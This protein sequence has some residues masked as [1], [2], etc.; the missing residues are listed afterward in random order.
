MVAELFALIGPTG[1]VIDAQEGKS[2]GFSRY[3]VAKDQGFAKA[4]ELAVKIASNTPLSNFAVLQALPRIADMSPPDGLFV[5]ALMIGIVQGDVAAKQRVRDFLEHLL[6]PGFASNDEIA[7]LMDVS[8]SAVDGYMRYF[9]HHFD[10][11]SREELVRRALLPPPALN[12]SKRRVQY[13]LKPADLDPQRS[14]AA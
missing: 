9:N 10:I 14:L 2:L 11:H 3:V 6:R 13:E 1:A 5:E 4:C 8:R 12:C 7:A